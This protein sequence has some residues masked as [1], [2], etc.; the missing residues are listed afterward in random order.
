MVFLPVGIAGEQIAGDG[1][2]LMAVCVEVGYH[3]LLIR[4]TLASFSAPICTGVMG[5]RSLVCLCLHS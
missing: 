5:F 3:I 2:V 1:V 4:K